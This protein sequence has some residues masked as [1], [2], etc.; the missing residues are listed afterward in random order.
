MNAPIPVLKGIGPRNAKIVIVTEAATADDLWRGFPLAGSAGDAFGAFLHEAGI[1]RSECYITS[2][3]KYR[4]K[5]DSTDRL[6]SQ[7]KAEAERNG[8]FHTINGTYVNPNIVPHIQAL[9]AELAALS[10]HV[11]LA[12]GPFA[13]FCLTEIYGSVDT[14]RGSHLEYKHRPE[15]T[16]IPTYTIR[17]IYARWELKSICVRDLQRVRAV[18]DHPEF[19]VYP[20][21]KFLIRPLYEQIMERLWYFWETLRTESLTLSCD[22][23]TVARQI[24]C[25]GLAWSAR[26]AI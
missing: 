21:Y 10:P 6:F 4:P 12:L 19:Y 18:A 7:N 3:L 24:S 2:V 22:I 26:E 8:L 11:I 15:I 9:H 1:I 14:W 13:M 17:D 23:E 5:G 25:I 20:S 16:V